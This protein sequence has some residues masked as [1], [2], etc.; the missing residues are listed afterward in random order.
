MWAFGYFVL[1]LLAWPWVVLRLHWRARREPAYG[2]RR[3]ER[4]GRVPAGIPPGCIWFHTVSAGE[5]IA[6]APLIGR[7]A[8]A[9]PGLPFLV[10]TMTPTGSAQVRERLGERVHHC[11]APYDFPWAVRRF[12]AAVRPRLVVLMETELW[13]N[14]IGAAAARGIPVLLVNAR[15]SE[16]SARGY[17][18]VGGLTRPMLERLAW[19]AC[20]YPDHARRFEALGAPPERVRVHGS[21]KFDAALPGDHAERVAALR[22][23][24]GLGTSPIWIAASTHPGEE[25]AVLAAHERIAALVPGTRLILVP[26]HPPRADEVIALCAARGLRVGRQSRVEADDA[27]A[28]VVVGDT[29]GELLYLYGAADVAFVGGSLVEVGGHNPIEPALCGVPMVMGPAVFNFEDVVR[30]FRDAGALEVV[31][32]PEALARV[33][34]GWL[35]DAERRADAGARA[36]AV[37]AANKGA[38]ARLEALLDEEIRSAAEV[39]AACRRA[40]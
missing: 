1:L 38:G 2:Q 32:D 25:Q 34:A 22:R 9:H 13:P 29:M 36:R 24:W 16:R 10:T 23:R 4:F 31:G 12:Y 14:L 37:V 30:S 19:I 5:T 33:V 6:A 7:L 20:Q 17:A 35:G 28:E 3:A 21:V 8:A 27:R 40:G 11:Y 26:R 15:L 39:D 18:R